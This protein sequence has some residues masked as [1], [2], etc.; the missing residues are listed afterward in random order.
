MFQEVAISGLLFVF[1]QFYNVNKFYDK[2]YAKS[3]KLYIPIRVIRSISK[4]MEIRFC[5]TVL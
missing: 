5:I 3:A 4:L 2:N 1:A